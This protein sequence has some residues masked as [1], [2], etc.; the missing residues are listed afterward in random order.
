M[1]KEDIIIIRITSAAILLAALALILLF[2][3]Q[4]GLFYR[5]I[6]MMNNNEYSNMAGSAYSEYDLYFFI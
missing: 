6:E 3:A 4:S 2:G 1:K 5:Y